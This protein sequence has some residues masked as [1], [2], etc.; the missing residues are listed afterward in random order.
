MGKENSLNKPAGDLDLVSVL[1]QR[2]GKRFWVDI[3]LSLRR[4]LSRVFLDHQKRRDQS[5]NLIF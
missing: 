4:S 1:Q 3:S 2:H 5:R